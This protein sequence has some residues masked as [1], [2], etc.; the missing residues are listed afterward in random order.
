MTHSDKDTTIPD[1]FLCNTKVYVNLKLTRQKHI[2]FIIFTYQA[3]HQ[4]IW[5]TEKRFIIAASP[6]GEPKINMPI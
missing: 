1:I 5:S 6:E 3:I 2:I 4:L